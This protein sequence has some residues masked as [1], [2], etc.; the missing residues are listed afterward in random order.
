MTS[1]ELLT[2]AVTVEEYGCV[3]CQIW[4][5]RGIDPEY[6]PHLMRQSKHGP[7][8]RPARLAERFALLVAADTDRD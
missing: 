4:H 5:R 8:R 7:R 3:Q 1:T 2:A 6:E